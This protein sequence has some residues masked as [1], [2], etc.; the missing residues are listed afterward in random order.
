[1]Q[2]LLHLSHF[3]ALKAQLFIYYKLGFYFCSLASRFSSGLIAGIL[4]ICYIPTKKG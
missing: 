1:M 4:E 2:R 3:L